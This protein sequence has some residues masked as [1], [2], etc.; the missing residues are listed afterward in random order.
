MQTRV[1]RRDFLRV[2]GLA[3]GTLFLTPPSRL[4]AQ[5][6]SLARQ[7]PAKRVLIVGAGL[8]GLTAAYELSEAG[9]D[10]TIL[11]ARTRPGGRVRTLRAPFADGLHAELGAARIPD[12]HTWTL[13]YV[14]D[15]GLEL[16]PFYPDNG[17]FTTFLRNSRVAIPPG[18]SADLSDLPVELTE[19]EREGGLDGLFGRAFGDVVDQAEAQADWPPEAL[20]P[21]DD[22]TIREFLARRGLSPDVYE[23]LGATMA[24]RH[25]A[26][27]VFRLIRSGHGS[28]V[29]HRI[30]G[31]SDLL[32][33]AFAAR[34]A[35]RI[36]YGTPVVR[37]E[38]DGA[39]VR[40]ICQHLGRLLAVEADKMICTIPFTVLRHLEIAPRFSAVKHQAIQ[41][42][43]YGSLS[44]VT[45]Q[46]R[47]RYW[48]DQ[49]DNGFAHTDTPG[50]IWDASFGQPGT[51]G[52]LQLYLQG[53]SSAYA[54]IMTEEERIRYAIEQ[55]EPVFPGLREVLEGAASHC[56]DNDP[57]TRGA[58]RLMY[59]GQVA[60]FHPHVAAP[61]GHI[62][63]A[64]EHTS[65]WYAWMNG[66]IESGSRAARE[67]NEA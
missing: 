24:A 64:G 20:A 47:R 18:E 3:A 15:F 17:N 52:L 2:G 60:T 4:A 38:Q 19:A 55:V 12:N 62:H 39:G 48:L 35:D 22:M 8:A 28:A 33:L 16:A 51:R 23:A 30:A 6:G 10:V 1:T 11:E 34:L 63:F 67:V 66:A 58:T 9:H 54:S 41:E 31:G 36:R 26:L 49:G 7:G 46:V 61:E 43:G 5:P 45:F 40:A 27:E 53:P 32:P 59:P 21:Y 13:K 50:E 37:L 25:S 14:R 56:W 57:W 29:M 65:L 42:M 44:R